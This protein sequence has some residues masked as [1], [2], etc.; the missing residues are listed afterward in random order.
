[1]RYHQYWIVTALNYNQLLDQ[2]EEDLWAAVETKASFSPTSTITRYKRLSTV[3]VIDNYYRAK[4]ELLEEGTFITDQGG[5]Y[6]PTQRKYGYRPQ[7]WK[8][9]SS[10]RLY[11][12]DYGCIPAQGDISERF[13]GVLVGMTPDVIFY[14]L[15]DY[16][17]RI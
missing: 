9:S 1:M 16:Y 6:W 4:N 5:F 3:S 7:V 14:K 11:V 15:K 10:S 12:P 13:I 17:D 2:H 8:S